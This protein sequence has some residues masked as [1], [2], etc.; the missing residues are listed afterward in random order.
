VRRW[1]DGPVTRFF[2]RFVAISGALFALSFLPF[3]EGAVQH[4][5]AL[6]AKWSAL[7]LTMTGEASKVQGATFLGPKGIIVMP[8]CSALEYVWFLCAAVLAFPA[9]GLKR[10]I[11]IGA[12]TVALL[13]LNLTR[14]ITLQVASVHFPEAFPFI[15]E[16]LWS[17]VLV[18]SILLF[19][20]LWMNWVQRE[21]H[22]VA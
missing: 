22:A 4:L 12:G 6:D 16:E 2:M 14:I 7:F 18:S 9:P 17:V 3:A 10:A 13:L 1:L 8:A 21:S 5:V 20:I 11:G 15:H 19:Y